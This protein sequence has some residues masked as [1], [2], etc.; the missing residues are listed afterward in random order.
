MKWTERV[1]AQLLTTNWCTLIILPT[2]NITSILWISVCHTHYLTRTLTTVHLVLIIIF[3][4]APSYSDQ[5]KE[6]TATLFLSFSPA[7]VWFH[8]CMNWMYQLYVIV[9]Q[10]ILRMVCNGI[11]CTPL[12]CKTAA[13][14]S[15][16]ERI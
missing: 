2:G 10:V 16:N 13:T 3:H 4:W 1:N 6:F 9:I 7:C 5:G 14:T 8:V 15:C 11:G 12:T